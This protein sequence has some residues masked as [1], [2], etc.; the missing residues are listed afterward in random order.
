[1]GRFKLI[2]TQQ[3]NGT[4]FCRAVDEVGDNILD[5]SGNGI[6]ACLYTP[7]ESAKSVLKQLSELK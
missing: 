4:W 5:E 7:L 6:E 2:F 3:N 1:M